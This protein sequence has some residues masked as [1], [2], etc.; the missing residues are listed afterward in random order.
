MTKKM[1]IAALAEISDEGKSITEDE[2]VGVL[3]KYAERFRSY[4]LDLAPLDLEKRNILEKTEKI[5]VKE[6]RFYVELVRRWVC[7]HR[8]LKAVIDDLDKSNQPAERLFLV[9]LSFFER[10]QWDLAKQEFE[11]NT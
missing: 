6:Y 8:S 9:G 10:Q 11:S 2:V 1:D 5:G 3:S 7:L 4:R